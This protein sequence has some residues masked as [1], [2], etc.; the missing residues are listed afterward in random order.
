VA[1]LRGEPLPD[2]LPPIDVDAVRDALAAIRDAVRAGDLASCHD[3]AEGGFL[4][5]VAECCLAGGLG[6]E[7]ELGASADRLAQLFGEGPGGFVVSGPEER[8]HELAQRIPL[9]VLG[10][11][12]GDRL[13]VRVADVAVEARLDELRE[14]HAALRRFFP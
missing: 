3:I 5:A 8:L 10:R 2:G 13:A 4:T 6:A 9:Q 11:V 14:A 12:G 7:L 1:K